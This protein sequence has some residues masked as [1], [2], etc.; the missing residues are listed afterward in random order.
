MRNIKLTIEYDGTYFHGW[1]VQEASKRTVQGELEKACRKVF[2]KRRRIIGSGRT[3]SGVHALGQIAH[4]KVET[5]LTADE[6][7][8]AL[9]ASLP[10]DIAIIKAEFAGKKFHAQYSAQAKTYR[11]TILNRRGRSPLAQNF[12]HFYPYPLN[13]ALMRKETKALIGRKDFKS[14]QATP[15]REDKEK[16]TVRVVKKI[17]ISKKG[18]FILIDIQANGFLHKMVRNIVGT[19]LEIGSGRLPKASMKRI[20]QKKSRL[21][22]GRTAKAKGLCLMEVKY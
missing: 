13:V 2:K 6:I 19:L 21:A 15:A 8:R 10:Q 9:N 1:Q 14:F 5:H 4:C 22:A 3:D 12:C 16:S 17:I 7:V 20:L 11:Y 18:D